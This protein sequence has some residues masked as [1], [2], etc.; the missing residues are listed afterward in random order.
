MT[1][2]IIPAHDEALLRNDTAARARVRRARGVLRAAW[3]GGKVLDIRSCSLELVRDHPD[4]AERQHPR[5]WAAW[6][7]WGFAD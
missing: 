4:N 6:V 2:V 7:P 1:S 5:Y 3:A